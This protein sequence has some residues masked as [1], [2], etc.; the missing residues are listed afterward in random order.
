MS[1]PRAHTPRPARSF[2][3]A[4]HLPTPEGGWG[5]PQLEEI[6]DWCRRQFAPG[7]CHFSGAWYFK[8]EEDARSFRARWAPDQRSPR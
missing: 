4:V 3:H 1:D 7:S 2:P 8:R 6:A 5:R